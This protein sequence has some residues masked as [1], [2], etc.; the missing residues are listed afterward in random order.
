MR[1][2]TKHVILTTITHRIH[3]VV[4]NIFRNR[5]G[6]LINNK[7]LSAYEV[8]IEVYRTVT[9]TVSETIV[10]EILEVERQRLMEK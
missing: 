6:I 10:K 7:N 1:K 8:G 3:E 2:P 4:W 5:N 9:Y